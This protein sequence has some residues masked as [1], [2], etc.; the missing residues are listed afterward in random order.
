MMGMN[1]KIRDEIK[2]ELKRRKIS[3]YQMSKDL[4][5]ATPNV[6]R[7][8]NGRSGKIPESWQKIFDYL[9]Y[10]ITITRKEK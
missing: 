2:S 7:L 9:G 4:E 3:H 1:A 6:A 8:L 5:M 10:E